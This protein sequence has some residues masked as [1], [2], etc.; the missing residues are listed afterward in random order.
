[1]ALTRRIIH[2]IKPASAEA[3]KAAI[4]R[5]ELEL[6]SFITQNPDAWEYTSFLNAGEL[7]DRD[8]VEAIVGHFNR[9]GLAPVVQAPNGTIPTLT[10]S[11]SAPN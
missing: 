5:V 1:M 3:A 9:R 7:P 10:L 6:G 11:W 2:N 8:A 4:R